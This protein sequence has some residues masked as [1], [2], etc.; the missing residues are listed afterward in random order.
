[1][2][3]LPSHKAFCLNHWM[4]RYE[5]FNF[6]YCYCTVVYNFQHTSCFGGTVRTSQQCSP[7]AAST[8]TAHSRPQST[9]PSPAH[10][11]ESLYTTQQVSFQQVSVASYNSPYSQ[12]K[13]KSHGGVEVSSQV[14]KGQGMLLRHHIVKQLPFGIVS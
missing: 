12:K 13:T 4:I 7:D 9:T 1:M 8:S 5:S 3:T 10:P 2:L 6:Q 11:A 14:Q